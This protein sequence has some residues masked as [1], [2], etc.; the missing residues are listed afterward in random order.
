[1]RS[2]GK[3]PKHSPRSAKQKAGVQRVRRHKGVTGDT[4]FISEFSSMRRTKIIIEN[5]PHRIKPMIN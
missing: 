1:M 5:S 3:T 2:V 4:C